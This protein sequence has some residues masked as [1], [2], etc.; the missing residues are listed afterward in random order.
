MSVWDKFSRIYDVAETLYNGKVFNGTGEVVARYIDPDD[1]VLECACGTGAISVSIAPVCRE[2]T[3]ADLSTG[4]LRQADKKLRGFS[5][6]RLR[7]ADITNLKCPDGSF[8]K[9]VAGNVIHLLDDP[10]KALSELL[11]VCRPGGRV[12]IPTYINNS[13]RSSKAAVSVIRR[14]GVDF[15]EDFDLASYRQFFEDMGCPAAEIRVVQGRMP[16]A[17]AVIDKQ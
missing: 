8:D 7:R 17:V 13:S 12:I 15:K 14:F 11:R 5:N 3:A 6:V 2:L 4:M 10:G 1:R 16:C 9:V